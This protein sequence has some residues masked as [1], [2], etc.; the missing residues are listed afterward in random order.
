MIDALPDNV[1]Q[2]TKVID[3]KNPFV[4]SDYIA[5]VT[6][7]IHFL[8]T[9]RNTTS[10]S[11]EH[12]AVI[13]RS[14]TRTMRSIEVTLSTPSWKQHDASRRSVIGNICVTASAQGVDH[15]PFLPTLLQLS[16]N[17]DTVHL[18]SPELLQALVEATYVLRE[19]LLPEG[20]SCGAWHDGY[21]FLTQSIQELQRAC[22]KGTQDA[23]GAASRNGT[24]LI[25]L[26]RR[27]ADMPFERPITHSRI[28]TSCY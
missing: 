4:P 21:A 14:L 8:L 12:G 22:T 5:A 27:T 10:Q 16:R 1:D 11:E 20:P 24:N 28:T 3:W 7:I 26:P 9:A 6:A 18:V 23:E 15:P 17:S 2:V 19:Y 13:D 25:P